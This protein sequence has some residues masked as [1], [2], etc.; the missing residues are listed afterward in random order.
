MTILLIYQVIELK[1]MDLSDPDEKTRFIRK[2][3]VLSVLTLCGIMV[4]YPEFL[5][6]IIAFGVLIALVVYLMV[7]RKKY[8]KA[9][10]TPVEV[11]T[12][13]VIKQDLDA[14]DD[15]I[16]LTSMDGNDE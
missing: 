10:E 4:V 2:I 8:K 7:T 1:K 16:V 15:D 5:T 12:G 11:V 14:E 9:P 3:I 13:E 6:T